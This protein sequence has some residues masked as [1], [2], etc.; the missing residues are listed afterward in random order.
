MFDESLHTSN[1]GYIDE[2]GTTTKGNPSSFC[3]IGIVAFLDLLGFSSSVLSHWNEKECN[4]LSRLFKIR[5]A[6]FVQELEKVKIGR[7]YSENQKS[8]DR[9]VYQ[10]KIHTFSD[11]FILSIALSDEI[12]MDEFVSGFLCIFANLSVIWKCSLDEGFIIRGGVELDSVYWGP[13][14][15]VGPALVKAYNLESKMANSARIIL[16]ANLLHAVIRISEKHQFDLLQLLIKHSDGLIGFSPVGI[17]QIQ[18]G[19][20]ILTKID[21]MRTQYDTTYIQQKYDELIHCVQQPVSKRAPKIDDLKSCRDKLKMHFDIY[22]QK[23]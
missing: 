20:D 19:H 5:N 13:S 6:P 22:R 2:H 23:N 18:K 12:F 1:I 17:A 3:G 8:V 21:Y 7:A 11:S 10:T 16:G 15:V 4:P 9:W 14:E